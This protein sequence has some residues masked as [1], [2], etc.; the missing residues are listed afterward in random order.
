MRNIYIGI[1]FRSHFSK[2][3]ETVISLTTASPFATGRNVK[4]VKGQVLGLNEKCRR[5]VSI[6]LYK[7]LKC[8]V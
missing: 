8:R 6:D 4:T 7:S 3:S 2:I 1:L 5:G